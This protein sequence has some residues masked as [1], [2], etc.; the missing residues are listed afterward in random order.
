MSTFLES[1]GIEVREGYREENLADAPDLVVIGN[2]ISRGNPEAETVLER[3]LR[4]CALPEVVE[5]GVYSRQ[6][7][8]CGGRHSWQDDHHLSVDVGI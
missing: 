5:R 1:R 2:A 6:T 3:K 4:Y 8:D 7:L